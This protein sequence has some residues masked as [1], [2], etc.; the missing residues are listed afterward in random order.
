M[1]ETGTMTKHME[2]ASMYIQMEQYMKVSGFKTNN[3]VWEQKYGQMEHNMKGSLLM[4]EKKE[5]EC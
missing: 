2:W 5:E 1:K 4:G 3:M